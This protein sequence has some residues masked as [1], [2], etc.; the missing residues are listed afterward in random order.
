[1]SRNALPADPAGLE[2]WRSYSD[3][4]KKAAYGNWEVIMSALA[5]PH[6]QPALTNF[7]KHVPCPRHGGTD[8]FRLYNDFRLTGGAV[9]NSCGPMP[10]GWAVLKWLYGWSYAECLRAVGDVVG[11]R[12]PSDRTAAPIAPKVK[13]VPPPP[14]ESPAQIARKNE[15]KAQR[16]T[17]AWSSS[18][19]LSHPDAEPARLYL[20]NR[21]LVNLVGPLEDL[22]YHPAMPYYENNI[23]HGDF[24]ALLCLLRQPSGEPLT[25]QRIFL[26]PDGHK[27]DLEHPKKMMPY[28]TTSQYGGSAVRLDHAVGTVLCV[29]EGVETGLAWRA[30]AGL[31]TWATCVAGL[32]EELVVPDSVRI[33]IACGDLDPASIGH[34]Y[35]RG[36][37][38]AHTLVARVRES[39]RLGAAFLPPYTLEPNAVSG[40]DWNDVLNHHGLEQARGEPFVVN[41]RNQIAQM[42]ERMGMGWQSALSHY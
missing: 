18:L 28:R 33:V 2:R 8:G 34:D 14:A 42:L 7:A 38:A 19:P 35:G 4:V 24:P 20:A 13:L 32:M 21:G 22:R 11:V 9:C 27:P 31:P 6:L 15:A 39:G 3:E 17:E 29:T 41:V 1:M 26:T 16:L 40:V 30:M 37:S 10:D 36:Y 23:K 12:H 25:L 5:G